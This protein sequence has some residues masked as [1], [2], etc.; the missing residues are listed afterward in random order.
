[1]QTSGKKLPGAY[2]ANEPKQNAANLRTK[3]WELMLTWND[4]FK[5]AN[6]PFR[7]NCL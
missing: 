3:G 4:A 7:Y 6:K 5:L 2:G 1:M